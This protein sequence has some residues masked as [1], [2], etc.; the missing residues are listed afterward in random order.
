M[1]ISFDLEFRKNPYTNSTYIALEGIDGSGKTTQ[2]EQLKAYFEK[3]GRNVTITSEPRVDLACG[4]IIMQFF[5]AEIALSALAFQHIATA[6][7]IV[8]QEEIVIPALKRGDV[9]ITDRCFWSAVPYG[10]MDKGVTFSRDETD[11]MLV[12][13]GLLS[14]Y[15]QTIVPDSVYYIDIKPETGLARSIKKKGR[16]EQ[17]VYE[18][19]DKLEKVVKGYHWLTKEFPDMFVTINGERPVDEITK[20]LIEHI[21]SS[22]E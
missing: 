22:N 12:A 18:K 2:R 3:K 14:H 19:K 6:N 20:D 8:N 13:Q 4:D 9:V 10:L 7:R 11:L 1:H 5:K 16:R 17:D 15:H 21:E